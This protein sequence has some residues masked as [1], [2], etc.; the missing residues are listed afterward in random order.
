MARIDAETLHATAELARLELRADEASRL[1]GRL[2]GVLDHFAALD[3]VDTAQVEP[4]LHPLAAELAPGSGPAA[5]PLP[6]AAVLANAPLARDGSFVVP[7]M[8]ER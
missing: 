6:Q 3:A 8:V 2:Q 1:L 5:E 7:R 4:A